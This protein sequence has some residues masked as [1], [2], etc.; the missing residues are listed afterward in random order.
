MNEPE[1]TGA[2]QPD[3]KEG[4]DVDAATE[5]VPQ[6]IGRYRIEKILGRGGFGLVY[7]AH[8]DHLQRHVALKFLRAGRAEDRKLRQRFLAEARS[9][10]ALNH[11]NVC[12]IYDVGE[13]DEQQPYLAMEYVEG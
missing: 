11:P 12:V 2:Y 4:P 7:L 10:S 5:V 1:R 3:G 6:R 13:T 9:A 8:D